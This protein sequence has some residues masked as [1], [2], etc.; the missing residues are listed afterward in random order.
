MVMDTLQVR[1]G[2]EMVKEVDKMIKTGLY[3]SRADVLRDA[4]RRFLWE[5]ELDKLVG[6]IPNT[7]DSVKE[8]RKIRKILSKQPFNM[9]E[10]NKLLD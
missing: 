6:S 4:L 9:G 8:V 1:I 7:G 5:R 3:S 2:H 10:L